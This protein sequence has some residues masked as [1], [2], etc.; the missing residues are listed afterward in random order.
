MEAAFEVARTHLDLAALA[1]ARGD[2]RGATAHLAEAARQFRALSVPRWVERAE[3][4]LRA[5]GATT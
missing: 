5:A 1:G 2:A 3:E 4:R